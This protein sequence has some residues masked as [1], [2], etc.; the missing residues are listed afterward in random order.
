M[1]VRSREISRLF[2]DDSFQRTASRDKSP[3]SREISRLSADDRLP[4]DIEEHHRREPLPVLHVIIAE[5]GQSESSRAE[6]IREE[7]PQL[8][9]VGRAV[10]ELDRPAGVVA[11]LVW[12]RDCR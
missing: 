3:R 1:S 2:A 7:T 11:H 10:E 5:V 6:E 8:G 12:H 4:E 9:A